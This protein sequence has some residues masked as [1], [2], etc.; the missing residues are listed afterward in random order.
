MQHSVSAEIKLHYEFHVPDGATDCPLLVAVHGYAAHMA[1]MMR[2]AKLVAPDDFAIASLQ[3]PNKFF[4]PTE[5]G[6]YKLAFGWLSDFKP[7]EQIALHH[8]FVLKVIEKHANKGTINP[9]R[10]YLYGFSQSCALNFRFAF[11]HPDALSG[12]VGVCGGIPSDFDENDAY[13]P[14]NAD[15]FYLYS[16]DDEFYP[17]EKF[18][19]FEK[20]LT[21]YLSNFESKLYKAKHEITD[22]MRDDMRKWLSAKSQIVKGSSV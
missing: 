19:G 17:L 13:A 3:G 11:T 18:Q 6:K 4:R 16:D 21:E 9:D 22:E 7:E 10:V 12:I 2:E 14:T 8:E 15:V 20:R 1:Y 5:D